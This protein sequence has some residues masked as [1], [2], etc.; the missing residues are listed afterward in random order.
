MIE[1]SD[2][3]LHP[4]PRTW[5]HCSSSLVPLLLPVCGLLCASPQVA[6]V[7]PP[8]PWH[9]H[10]HTSRGLMQWAVGKFCRKC[11]NLGILKKYW[12]LAQASRHSD[13]IGKRCPL[14]TGVLISYPGGSYGQQG[15]GT[16][17]L[18]PTAVASPRGMSL[19]T[20]LA[21]HSC[22]LNMDNMPGT[23]LGDGESTEN[24][25]TAWAHGAGILIK[26]ADEKLWQNY[27]EST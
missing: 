11:N 22:L 15:C 23:I 10:I 25:V 27:K 3:S 12:C 7:P 5:A 13:L 26:E 8:Q 19:H 1:I 2:E 24:K 9:T 16:A 17:S 20:H 14:G 21:R 18:V 4:A 6:C